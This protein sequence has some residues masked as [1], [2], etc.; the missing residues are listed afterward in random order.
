MHFLGRA[1]LCHGFGT[2]DNLVD[3]CPAAPAAL[4]TIRL[5]EENKQMPV[6]QATQLKRPL[7]RLLP[8][9]G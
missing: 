9:Q 4:K 6:S 1:S 8:P 5:F 3:G 7:G 2:W